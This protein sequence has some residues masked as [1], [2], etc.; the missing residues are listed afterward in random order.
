MKTSQEKR[1]LVFSYWKNQEKPNPG[2]LYTDPLFPPN[3]NS[4]LGLDKNGKI[5]DNK[6]YKENVNEIKK[7]EIEFM[8]AIDIF[9][10]KYKLFSEKIEMDD[11]IQG[12]LGDCYFL[13]S[14]ANLCKFPGF[15]KSL[16]KTNNT[17]IDGYYEIIFN[18]DGKKQIVFVDDYFPVYKKNKWP[19]FAQPNGKEIWVMLLEKAWAKINGGYVNIIGGMASQA[20]ECLTGYGSL[21]YNT[22]NM[23]PEELND[24]KNEIINN[25][26]IADQ[27]HCLISCATGDFIE[28]I[29]EVGLI[30][31]H[32]YSI[33]NISQISTSQGKSEYLFK[34]RNPWG[35][36]EW[37]GDWSDKSPLWTERLKNQLDYRDKEDGIFFMNESDF[38][39]YFKYITICYILYNSTSIKYTIEG[40]DNLKNASVFNIETENEG[41]LS[42][43]ALRKNW[44][45]NRE[46]RNK[47]FPT[48]ISIVKYNKNEKE[49]L[50][51]FS[52]YKGT[53][54][55]YE[56]CTLNIKV[57]KGN[58]LIYVYRYLEKF[59]FT[60][61]KSMD[62]KITC[63]ANLK[64][65]QMAYD[66]RNKGFPLLQNIILQAELNK[67]QLNL[68]LG[69]DCNFSTEQIGGNGI[70]GYIYYNSIPGNFNKLLINQNKLIMIAPYLGP[71]STSFNRV[72]PSGKYFVLLSLLKEERALYSLKVNPFTTSENLKVE[73]DD[74]D[75]DLSLYTDINNDIKSENF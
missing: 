33:L 19:C 73:Y 46:L 63:T 50:K 37:N 10:S 40:I 62:I 60:Q 52:D 20:L 65:A 64:H 31:A 55:S 12:S 17:N 13:S 24:Y 7:D 21:I 69:E 22:N 2:I 45:T 58:Y 61:E 48:H 11:V 44:R 43:S 39:K 56:T 15:I 54:T 66:E 27:N 8:R 49:R 25:I 26:K 71:L 42:V 9:G 36:K 75:I 23:K 4:L 5:I 70:V 51:I 47:A 18:I 35:Q 41:L 72:I 30:K 74:N 67:R 16:F 34:I 14:V 3:V 28:K 38:F 68:N 6:A 1:K 29:E 32:A 59:D 53:Y 57:K